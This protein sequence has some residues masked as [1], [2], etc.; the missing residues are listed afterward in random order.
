MLWL[1]RSGDF[2]QLLVTGWRPPRSFRFRIHSGCASSANRWSSAKPM[3]LF[4]PSRSIRAATYTQP[5]FRL[6]FSKRLPRR[7]EL[8]T[9]TRFARR[10]ARRIQ[11]ARLTSHSHTVW[12]APSEASVLPSG[13]NATPSTGPRIVDAQ[14]PA[15]VLAPRPAG[16][17]TVCHFLEAIRSALP[18]GRQRASASLEAP[19][20]STGSRR[21]GLG[22]PKLRGGFW[23]AGARPTREGSARDIPRGT[24]RR[25]PGSSPGSQ[26]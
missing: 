26:S 10:Q 4:L 18:A 1:R 15:E 2:L 20:G 11:E 19:S 25:R 22:R 3:S 5:K 6:P 8:I 17:I 7:R 12:S 16:Q 21:R 23:H 9:S 24:R 14:R 13:L